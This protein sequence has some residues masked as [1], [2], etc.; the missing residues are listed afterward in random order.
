MTRR[1][2]LAAIAGSVAAVAVVTL[3]IELFKTFVPVLSLGV[4]YVV[5][6]PRR[7]GA[8]GDAV[9]VP[10]CGREHARVQLVPS[11]AA[12][13]VHA[14][15]GDE[16]VRARRYV[17]VAVTVSVL[18][19]RVRRRAA[20]AE[21]R[22]RE[23]ALL[24]DV[25]RDLLGGRELRGGARIDLRA[26]RGG[27]GRE[28]GENRARPARAAR[29]R[30]AAPAGGRQ[31]P[32]R[33]A[34]LPEGEAPNIAR[35]R[36]FPAGSGLAGR[37][38]RRPR[39]AGARGDRRGCASAERHGQ[40]GRPAGGVAR[41]A[42]AADGDPGSGGRAP[43][44]G[45]R[46]RRVRSCGARRDDRIEARRLDRLVSNLL[47][48]SRLQADA[49]P[50]RPSSGRSTS[51]WPR[52]S[53]R[54]RLGAGRRRLRAR[55]AAGRGR[56]DADSACAR[57]P[58]RERAQVLLARCAGPGPGHVTRK[59]AIVRVVDQGPGIPESELER[60]FEPF[61]R[62][63]RRR[64]RRRARARDRTRVRA[65][66]RRPRLGRV[67]PGAGS[68]VRACAPLVEQPAATVV[69]KRSSSSTTSRRSCALS[70]RTS[71]ARATR[72]RRLRPR[73]R[74]SRTRRCAPPDA[75]ILDL[76]LPDGRGT[77]VCRELRTWTDVP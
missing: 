16:L 50:R 30:G 61:H 67:A 1:Q 72:S 52:R 6:G 43:L 56:R 71:A 54:S 26:S 17:V 38:R 77:D 36:P 10:R 74:R 64:P 53:K 25:A 66:E 62:G 18:A 75:V 51:S 60:I 57:E 46:A 5:R 58:A 48:L 28:P 44:R 14:R 29:G 42:L 9:R 59:E 65:G 2:Q 11:A 45:G 32:G 20:E 73:R 31:A 47:E 76:V 49:A 7:R 40:D 3:A 8:V 24:A 23:A 21:Q 68:F 70:R 63:R 12:S 37:G 22:E 39:A 19:D 34:L 69:T 35:A 4:L 13:H 27:T 33:H 41:P 55:S 15:G